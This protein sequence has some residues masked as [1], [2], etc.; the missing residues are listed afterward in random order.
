MIGGA[1]VLLRIIMPDETLRAFAPLSV[2][3]SS[4]IGE[5]VSSVAHSV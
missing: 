5:P 3:S 1:V 4:I 2:T